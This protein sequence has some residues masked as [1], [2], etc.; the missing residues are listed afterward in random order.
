MVCGYVGV[1]CCLC[2]GLPS[3]VFS[4]GFVDDVV[5]VR[6]AAPFSKLF[7]YLAINGYLG[8][9]DDYGCLVVPATNYRL[10][11]YLI[12]TTLTGYSLSRSWNVNTYVDRVVFNTLVE[13]CGLKAVGPELSDELLIGEVF[14]LASMG[15]L[16]KGVTNDTVIK[17]LLPRA[18]A[19]RLMSQDLSELVNYVINTPN[20]ISPEALNY[21]VMKWLS[22]GPTPKEV[23]AL[24]TLLKVGDLHRF[25]YVTKLPKPSEVR[26]VDTGKH[27]VTYVIPDENYVKAQKLLDEVAKEPWRAS[28]ILKCWWSIIKEELIEDLAMA[29]IVRGCRVYSYREILEILKNQ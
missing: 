18:L 6:L 17:T 3:D 20:E 4:I 21:L 14:E 10:M 5:D 8:F 28:K 9:I 23:K 1:W 22:T 7:W 16:P 19:Y 25:I 11:C 2:C 27:P 29:L 13:A 24:T 26:Y 15:Y 12:T